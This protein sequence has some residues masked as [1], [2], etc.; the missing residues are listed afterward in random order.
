MGAV[1]FSLNKHLMYA[2]I[3]QRDHTVVCWGSDEFGQRTPPAGTENRG[4]VSI[5][6]GFA[7]TCGVEANGLL[8]CW[9]SGADGRTSVVQAQTPYAQ[10]TRLVESV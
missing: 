6:C 10:V 2:A 7:H 5:S 4:F 9:G 3:T 1:K 8:H